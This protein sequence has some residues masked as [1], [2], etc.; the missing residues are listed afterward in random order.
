MQVG[1]P[2]RNVAALRRSIWL[3]VLTGS[4]CRPSSRALQGTWAAYWKSLTYNQRFNIASLLQG[5]VVL[6]TIKGVPCRA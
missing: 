3:H 5:G 6:I 1:K 4:E 2:R